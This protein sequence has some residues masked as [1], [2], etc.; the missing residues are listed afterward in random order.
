MKQTPTLLWIG[1]YQELGE[2]QERLGRERSFT[3]HAKTKT[4]AKNIA[5]E[6]LET[7]IRQGKMLDYTHVTVRK[8]ETP[9]TG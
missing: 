8:Y 2:N 7:K 6:R 1:Q 4:Q 3:I 9:P 5:I